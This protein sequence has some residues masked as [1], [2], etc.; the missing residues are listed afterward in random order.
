LG[1]LPKDHA[2]YKLAELGGNPDIVVPLEVRQRYVG[3]P[4]KKIKKEYEDSD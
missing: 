1:N 3:E 2:I 4:R